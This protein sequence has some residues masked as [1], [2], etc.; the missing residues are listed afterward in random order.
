MKKILCCAMLVGICLG[1]SGVLWSETRIVSGD[2]TQYGDWGD[3]DPPDTTNYVYVINGKSQVPA[4]KTLRIHAGVTVR[5]ECMESVDFIGGL[6][7][8]GS[9]NN[10]IVIQMVTEAEGF[11]FEGTADSAA[12]LSHVR[13]S[14]HEDSVPKHALRSTGRELRV[15]ECDITARIFPIRCERAP[16]YISKCF[17]GKTGGQG[18]AIGLEDADGSVIEQ[19]R[20]DVDFNEEANN[21]NTFGIDMQSSRDVEILDNAIEVSGPGFPIGLYSWG[22]IN[23]IIRGNAIQVYINSEGFFARG[24]WLAASR[25]CSVSSCSVSVGY[26]RS[27]QTAIWL[28]GFT[29]TVVE[30]SHLHL[31][32]GIGEFFHSEGGAVYTSYGC[33][34]SS[35]QRLEPRSIG[36]GITSEADVGTIFPNPFNVTTT[37]PLELYS[38]STVELVVVNMLGREVDRISYGTLPNGQHLLR[39]SGSSWASGVYLI[40]PVVNG[41]ALKMQKIFLLK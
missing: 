35:S 30:N 12:V 9:E 23:P 38:P 6:S 21:L 40:Q 37:L 8:E 3:V 28:S 14:S 39:L 16:A 31:E 11:R 24:I 10:P 5:V 41:K 29:S 17:I 7:A 18:A 22:N 4:D 2:L 32:G 1:L 33:T 19:C 13:F 36:Q 27:Q 20:I 34:V 25:Y 26:N 15:M